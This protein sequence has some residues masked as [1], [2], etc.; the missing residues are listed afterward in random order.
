VGTAG[1]GAGSLLSDL[2]NF[3]YHL[4]VK[5]PEAGIK[6]LYTHYEAHSAEICGSATD[7][8]V[9]VL[10]PAVADALS[11]SDENVGVISI[12]ILVVYYISY[13]VNEVDTRRGP[14]YS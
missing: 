11:S 12:D 9:L 10:R 6:P 5:N 1:G 13:P 2:R 8:L 14:Q 3:L 7:L 4:E